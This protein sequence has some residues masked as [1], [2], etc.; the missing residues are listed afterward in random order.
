M[1]AGYSL[2]HESD[3]WRDSLGKKLKHNSLHYNERNTHHGRDGIVTQLSHTTKHYN[4]GK[5]HHGYDAYGN[6]KLNSLKLVTVVMSV[7]VFEFEVLSLIM[8]FM[9]AHETIIGLITGVMMGVM[10]S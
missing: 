9:G 1:I 8:G 3:I 10:A 2:H 5:C 6:Q 7:G 4:G